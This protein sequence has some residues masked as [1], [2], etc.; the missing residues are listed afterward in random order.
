[1]EEPLANH[2]SKN[3]G[4]LFIVHLNNSQAAVGFRHIDDI[5]YGRVVKSTDLH[6]HSLRFVVN[7]ENEIEGAEACI[8]ENALWK[9]KKK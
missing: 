8:L 5:I 1:M 3:F 7:N 9:K 6:K 4:S 2:S